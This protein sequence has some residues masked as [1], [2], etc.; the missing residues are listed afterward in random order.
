MEQPKMERI[1]Y[2]F[3]KVISNRANTVEEKELRNLYLEFIN[4]CSGD[5]GKGHTNNFSM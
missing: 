1:D 3:K 4:G 2:L 5:L